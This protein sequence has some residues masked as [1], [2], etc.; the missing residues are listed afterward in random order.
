MQCESLLAHAP[1]FQVA[2]VL[3]RPLI[4]ENLLRIDS[5]DEPLDDVSTTA[6]LA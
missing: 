1:V 2:V 5:D 4:A 3:N 6:V